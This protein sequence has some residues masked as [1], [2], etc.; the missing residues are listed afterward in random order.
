[1]LKPIRIKLTGKNL[2][3]RELA[4]LQHH[5][6]G[7]ASHIK[8][9]LPN[10]P[11]GQSHQF[12]FSSCYL[13]QIAPSFVL[14]LLL[15]LHW[16]GG[17]S[18]QPAGSQTSFCVGKEVWLWGQ[19]RGSWRW[20]HITLFTQEIHVKRANP[21]I[22]KGHHHIPG[23]PFFCAVHPLHGKPDTS[24]RKYCSRWNCC[25][26]HAQCWRVCIF[27]SRQQLVRSHSMLI[28]LGIIFWQL[29]MRLRPKKIISNDY[30]G[31]TG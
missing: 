9:M 28:G 16:C 13:W 21:H 4:S 27:R 24:A 3:C 1:M 22:F 30:E 5:F 29:R 7:P 10:K 6:T 20:P 25:R 12:G 15:D 18:G 14:A 19:A 8:Q 26:S 23:P 17:K 11:G 2:S 31:V